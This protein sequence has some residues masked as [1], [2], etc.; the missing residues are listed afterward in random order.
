MT[1]PLPTRSRAMIRR[2]ASNTAGSTLAVT[3]F[4]VTMLLGVA[5]IAVDY[6]Y[7]VVVKQRLQGTADAA[8]MAGVPELPDDADGATAIAQAYAT[9]NMSVSSHG[10]VLVASDVTPGRWN[11]S[12]RVFS[13]NTTPFNA[14]RTVTRRS[15]AGP[16]PMEIRYNCSS[17]ES[18]ASTPQM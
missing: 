16:R 3:A 5:A 1:S 8:A 6:G 14:L 7:L 17:R 11:S 10:T 13:P 9:T 15:H 4:A 18:L 12:T 2:F